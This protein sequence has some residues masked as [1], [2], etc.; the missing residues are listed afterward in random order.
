MR[1]ATSCAPRGA[2]PAVEAHGEVHVDGVAAAA[3]AHVAHLAHA[4]DR[5]GERGEPLRRQRGAVGQHVEG[6]EQDPHAPARR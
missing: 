4:G 6:R 5:G 3:R 1:S 2:D